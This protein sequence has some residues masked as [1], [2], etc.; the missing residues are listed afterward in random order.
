MQSVQLGLDRVLGFVLPDHTLFGVLVNE[1]LISTV[2]YKIGL[3]RVEQRL[4]LRFSLTG[5]KL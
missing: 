1:D 5:G 4:V 3:L 2:D